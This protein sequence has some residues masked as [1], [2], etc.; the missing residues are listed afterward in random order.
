MGEQAGDLGG[1]GHAV[2]R[3]AGGLG[4]G[5]LC[6]GGGHPRHNQGDGR[7]LTG[8][9]GTQAGVLGA[10]G[11]EVDEVVVAGLLLLVVLGPQ[12][13]G[14]QAQ[15][16]GAADVAALVLPLVRGHLAGGGEGE[17]AA[18][19]DAV[20]VVGGLAVDAALVLALLV[21]VELLEAVLGVGVVLDVVALVLLDVA[22]VLEGERAAGPPA[23]EEGIL[24]E[25]D[26]PTGFS[27]E[28]AGS[29]TAARRFTPPSPAVRGLLA[30]PSAFSGFQRGLL[31][32]KQTTNKDLPKS[33][34]LSVR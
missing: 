26:E 2:G 29:R 19:P 22:L 16:P 20:E 18:R 34:E 30:T 25:G 32:S 24:G 7:L 5:Q 14:G 9:G 6:R 17:A 31:Q 4:G 21:L 3:L 10:H 15:H 27:C 11:G 8:G 12:E 33:Y 28:R 13:G 1:R 23:G